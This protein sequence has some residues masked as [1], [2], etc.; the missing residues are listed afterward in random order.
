MTGNKHDTY[1]FVRTNFISFHRSLPFLHE[2]ESGFFQHIQRHYGPQMR[3]NFRSYQRALNQL[4]TTT[5]REVFLLK[6]RRHG[7]CPRFILDKVHNLFLPYAHIPNCHTQRQLLQKTLLNYEISNCIKEKTTSATLVQTLKSVIS[8]CDEAEQFLSIN[9]TSFCNKRNANNQQLFHKFRHLLDHQ[10]HVPDIHYEETFIENISGEIIPY[11]MSL[12]LS[13][14]PKFALLPEKL[15]IPDIVRDVEYIVSRSAHPSI[16]NAV[17][18]QMAYTITRHSK[19]PIR[20]NRVHRF[21]QK[22]ADTTSDFLKNHPHVFI[23]NSDKGNKTIICNKTDYQQKMVTRLSNP[24]DFVL[25]ND[26]PTKH[27]ERA[28]NNKIDRLFNEGKYN[29]YKKL[30]LKSTTGIAPRVY[31]LYK[32]HK[33][34]HPL[35]LI[36]STIKS[37]TY[38]LAK[39]LSIIL[40]N[41]FNSPKY[42]L[43][44]SD[45]ALAHIQQHRLLRDHQ[46]VSFDMVNCFGSIPIDLIIEL[47]SQQFSS[48]QPHTNLTME[49]FVDLL[50]FCLRDGNYMQYGDKFYRQR[51]GIAMGS[52]LGS[53]LVQICT[54]HIIDSV[55]SQLKSERI[56]APRLWKVYVDDHILVCRADSIPHVLDKLNL[57][58]PLITFTCELEQECRLNYL[59]LTLIRENSTIITNWYTKSIASGRIINFMSAHPRHMITNT[60]LAFAR[61]VFR[62]SSSIFHSENETRIKNILLKNSF[63]PNE[64]HKIIN[65]AKTPAVRMDRHTD[66]VNSNHY[67]LTYVPGTS[68]ALRKHLRYFLPDSNLAHKPENKL[69]QFY[70]KKKDPLSE[71]EQSDVVYQIPCSD[72]N[73]IYIG[74]TT[75]RLKTRLQQHKSTVNSSAAPK[76][77]LAKHAKDNAHSFNFDDTVIL[78]RNRFK[79]KLQICEVNHIIMNQENTCNFKSDTCHISPTYY[80]LLRHHANKS[81]LAPHTLSQ[82]QPQPNSSLVH[83]NNVAPITTN[84]QT[85]QHHPTHAPHIT[86]T[87]HQIINR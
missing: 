74:E 44:N 23:S 18:S 60:A 66:N 76:T 43:K 3:D 54:E 9:Y 1:L 70:S 64:I 63:P 49:I 38:N 31:G 45:E 79:R 26:D 85:T 27:V 68:E 34:G 33:D 2:M 5:A 53:I 87:T 52:S 80:N 7:I 28:L 82:S 32:I 81:N 84:S 39:D 47:V 29:K 37:P 21:L 86:T 75:Q 65:I 61:K 67:A 55:L 57:F 58:H 71:N 46:L 62:F 14:G 30:H 41:A 42:S 6:C 72:C 15:P 11:E 17:R 4:C 24:E 36:A 22:C 20:P 78:E 50:G 69:N 13:L 12:L 35:R 25:L 77:A 83:N 40:T 51:N 73:A 56:I 16:I 10:Q 8:I 19:I 48:I 59:D